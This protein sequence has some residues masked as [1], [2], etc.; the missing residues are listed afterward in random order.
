MYHPHFPQE[1]TEVSKACMAQGVRQV[2]GRAGIPSQ[3]CLSPKP[4]HITTTASLCNADKVSFT[5]CRVLR[6]LALNPSIPHLGRGDGLRD[7]SCNQDVVQPRPGAV[8]SSTGEGCNPAGKVVW[9]ASSLGLKFGLWGLGQ[10][11]S[12]LGPSIS[13][14]ISE[15]N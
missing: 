8:S 6:Q 3:A 13:C 12:S 4:V 1:E 10:V 9:L 11:I 7:Y 14:S 15:E 5:Q 2:G